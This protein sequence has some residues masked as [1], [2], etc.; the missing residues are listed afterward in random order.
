MGAYKICVFSYDNRTDGDDTGNCSIHHRGASVTDASLQ[1]MQR[2]DLLSSDSYHIHQ[3]IPHSRSK[4]QHDRGV[5][6]QHRG[7]RCGGD[8][9]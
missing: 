4:I 2:S 3:Q 5:L 1:N 7:S 9:I 6:L 8:H